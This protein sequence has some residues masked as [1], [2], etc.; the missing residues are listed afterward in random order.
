VQDGDQI[1]TGSGVIDVSYNIE[2]D[3][4]PSHLAN[5]HWI[6]ANCRPR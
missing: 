3:W 4:S 1:K 6:R 2:P 5:T